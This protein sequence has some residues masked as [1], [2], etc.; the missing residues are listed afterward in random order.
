[1][2]RYIVADPKYVP[3]IGG[4]LARRATGLSDPGFL[5]FDGYVSGTER[6]IVSQFSVPGSWE[7][8]TFT[9]TAK[10]GGQ[11]TIQHP[12]LSAPLTGTAG[13]ALKAETK[14]GP[15]ELLVN[16]LAAKPGAQFN[17][18][19][20]HIHWHAHLPIVRLRRGV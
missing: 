9:L 17:L 13:T 12:A 20:E 19:V 7:G 4:W 5:G 11:F 18:E 8:S 10:S 16:E 6:I 14:D 2:G 1:M 3:Y 15:I